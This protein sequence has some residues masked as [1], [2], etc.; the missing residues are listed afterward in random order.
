MILLSSRSPVSRSLSRP[1][2]RTITSERILN[3]M[4]LRQCG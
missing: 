1:Q 4:S 2:A 3:A